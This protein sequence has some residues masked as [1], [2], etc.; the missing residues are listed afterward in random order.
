MSAAL[1]SLNSILKYSQ[2]R[3]Q[4]KIDRSLSLLDLGTK[5]KQQEL[6][7]NERKQRLEFDRRR[8]ELTESAEKEK[9]EIRSIE[10]ERLLD[11]KSAPKTEFQEAQLE[12]VKLELDFLKEKQVESETE[13][14][15]AALNNDVANTEKILYG[16]IRRTKL[17][18]E[19]IYSYIESNWDGKETDLKK[20][21]KSFAVN[22]VEIKEIENFL[23]RPESQPLI[24]S[25]M[26]LETS[27]KS[28]SADYTPFLKAFDNL[29]SDS[30][31]GYFSGDNKELNRDYDKYKKSVQEIL[32][33]GDFY[34]E[35]ENKIK[36]IKSLTDF[37][38]K[39]VNKEF[40]SLLK[41]IEKKQEGADR[42][43]Y[44]SI[45]E[46]RLLLNEINPATGKLFTPEEA[47]L[48]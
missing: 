9:A 29:S 25:L 24:S 10:K 28:G 20:S 26:Y 7:R 14:M 31:I 23:K 44:F 19:K 2:A 45:E 3:E 46:R 39:K 40:D 33:T 22:D 8:L 18:P 12:K 48:R 42:D 43:S 6:D 21:I 5:L 35:E 41:E 17:I 4:Q 11:P 16:G 38:S 37:S 34:K 13:K 1:D 27:K 36:I 15:F 47:G 30:Q 32:G